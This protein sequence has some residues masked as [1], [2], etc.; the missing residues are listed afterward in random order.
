MIQGNVSRKASIIYSG[1]EE[2]RKTLNI[3]EHSD[4][5]FPV[6]GDGAV[7]MAI[8]R[9]RIQNYFRKAMLLDI[10]AENSTEGEITLK[11]E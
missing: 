8:I 5:S 7:F 2:T 9:I 11:E 3:F 6:I 4:S 10:I 1:M